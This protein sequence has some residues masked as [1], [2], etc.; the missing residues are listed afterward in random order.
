MAQLQ[1]E[2]GAMAVLAVMLMTD[3]IDWKIKSL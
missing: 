1:A 2:S 3:F